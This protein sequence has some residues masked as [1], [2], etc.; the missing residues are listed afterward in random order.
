MIRNKLYIMLMFLGI[1]NI[2]RGQTDA[3]YWFDRDFTNRVSIPVS[4]SIDV[5]ASGLDP[6]VH[7]LYFLYMDNNSGV[8]SSTYSKSFLVPNPQLKGN[9]AEY[10]FDQKYSSRVTTTNIGNITVDA[11]GLGP[12]LHTLYYHQL[13]T[14][15]QAS[16]TYAY[17]F[18]VP[19]PQAKAARG[20]Y[21]FDRNYDGR[22]PLALSSEAVAVDLSEL[23]PGLHSLRYHT[24]DA[25]GVPSATYSGLFWIG[26]V[27]LKYR[28]WV[29]DLEEE[30]QTV[31]FEK[32][33][34]NFM[35]TLQIDVPE[36]PIRTEKYHFEMLE[37]QPKLYAK[38][39][40][41]ILFDNSDGT[42]TR[43]EQ[44]Y[45]DY[46]VSED[47]EAMPLERGDKKTV[48]KSDGI[49]WFKVEANEGD[50]L[51]FKLSRLCTVH[52]FSSS[53]KELWTASGDEVL[54][55]NGTKADIDGSFYLAVQDLAD[56]DAKDITVEYCWNPKGD[57]NCDKVTDGKDRDAIV[58]H[59][60]G[61]NPEVFDE[62]A[63]DINNDNKV[64]A[65]DVVELNNLLNKE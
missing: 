14:N 2:A 33:D 24:L 56:A 44:D 38:N 9:S 46:R 1:C 59:I 60:M 26:A 55:T 4:S 58:S 25:A 28:Y 17:S 7:T 40:L 47:I 6:G 35:H 54:L 3:V 39:T 30:S 48:D 53:N 20:E 45:V 50:M 31:L 52:L 22:K 10:W 43:H 42:T 64:N 21:W 36:L 16:S 11:S 23:T 37:D 62:T 27:A 18:L 15:G 12:G 63:A 65:A 19:K 57:A 32:T 51:S 34:R 13:Y 41:T 49:K 5:D 8:P 61:E 29:N